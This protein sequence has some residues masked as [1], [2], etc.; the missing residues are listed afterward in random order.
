MQ[1]LGEVLQE[2]LNTRE[3]KIL[4]GIGA[5]GLAVAL[6]LAKP[7]RSFPNRLVKLEESDTCIDNDIYNKVRTKFSVLP[8]ENVALDRFLIPFLSPSFFPPGGER[9]IHIWRCSEN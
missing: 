5:T 9:R 6:Y 4:T 2:I 3:G 8:S 1:N 7:P